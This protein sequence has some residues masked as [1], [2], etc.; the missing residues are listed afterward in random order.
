MSV[1][2]V[3]N[4]RLHDCRRAEPRSVAVGGGDP[5]TVVQDCSTTSAK[6]P[7]LNLYL[8]MKGDV[9][10]R[11]LDDCKSLVN[12]CSSSTSF[13]TFIRMSAAPITVAISMSVEYTINHILAK[14]GRV[15]C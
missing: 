15:V 1:V 10:V 11:F 12:S 6:S 2:R 5:A 8:N 13:H 3:P 7:L 4:S 14:E 9:S